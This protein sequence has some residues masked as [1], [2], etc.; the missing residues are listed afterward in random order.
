MEKNFQNLN[1]N[2]ETKRNYKD[3]DVKNLILFFLITFLWSYSFWFAEIFTEKRFYLGPFG[4]TFAALI[5]TFAEGKWEAVKKLLKRGISLN[6]KKIWLIP[7]F[8]LMPTIIGLSLVI[9]ILMGEKVPEFPVFK[10]PLIIIPAFFMIFFLG[11]PLAEEFGWRGYAL[12]RLQKKF[13]A[14]ISSIILGF[15][16]GLWHIPLFFMKGQEIYNNIPIPA[17]IFGTILLSTLFT[18]I[19]NNTNGSILA[20]LIFHT[21]GN[22]SHFIFPTLSTKFGG[23]I[24]LILNLLVIIIIIIVFGAKRMSKNSY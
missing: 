19:Y 18:F 12:Y 14:L 5:L 1:G 20:A 16:W 6:F 9:A 2:N 10:Q 17:F 7:T 3:N 15:I 11:G 24:S 8:L 21:M 4:P 13:N 23:L 22:L